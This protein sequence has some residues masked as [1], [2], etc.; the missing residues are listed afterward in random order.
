MSIGHAI[1]V[2]RA[3]ARISQVKLAKAVGVN[4]S[5]ISMI[6]NDDYHSR[7]YRDYSEN[8]FS[9]EK[10]SREIKNLMDSLFGMNG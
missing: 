10:Q 2:Q 9:F 1:K 4:Q 3:I 5:Y 8:N 7:E 6:E